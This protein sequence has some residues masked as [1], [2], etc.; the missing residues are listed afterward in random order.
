MSS[1]LVLT[2]DHERWVKRA[3][4]KYRRPREYWREL[5]RRQYGSCAFSGAPL[6]FDATSGTPIKGGVSQHPL[7]A[8]V[9]HCAP[10][11][12]DYGHEIVC[13][14]L[15]DIKGHLPYACFQAL[16]GTE[17]WQ[18]FMLR[19]RQQAEINPDRETLKALRRGGCV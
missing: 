11:S 14:D 19:W 12:D 3:C 1:P 18:Q 6:F 15:N 2:E 8:V 13:N 16:R 4:G 5:I 10:G 9:D 7:Y 17:A